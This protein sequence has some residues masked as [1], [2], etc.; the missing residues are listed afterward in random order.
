MDFKN[1]LMSTNFKVA[2]YEKEQLS[3]GEILAG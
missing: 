3:P 1:Y 2:I